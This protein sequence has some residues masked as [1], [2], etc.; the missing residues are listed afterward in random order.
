M[1]SFLPFFNND[2]QSIA[3][4]E[5]STQFR[6]MLWGIAATQ[7]PQYWL[8]GKGLATIPMFDITTGGGYNDAL[9]WFA[10]MGAF[11][12]GPLGLLINFGAVGLLLGFALFFYYSRRYVLVL[13]QLTKTKHYLIYKVILVHSL[14]T[15]FIFVFLYGD[16]QSNFPD[17]IFLLGIVAIYLNSIGH[18]RFTNS[19][20]A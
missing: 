1:F 5:G 15:T 10:E 8:L 13:H 3:D 4:A 7:I 18:N 6:L 20:I 12:N 2:N 11:H 17:V 9:A 14:I 16:M 19:S